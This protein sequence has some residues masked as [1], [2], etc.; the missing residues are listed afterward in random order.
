[1]DQFPI[2]ATSLAPAADAPLVAA[3]TT[4]TCR[5]CGEHLF[6]ATEVTHAQVLQA[7]AHIASRHAAEFVWDGDALAVAGGALAHVRLE[8]TRPLGAW[9]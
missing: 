3:Q 6:T 4:A 8:V 5:H 2:S 1:M 7:E 9:S